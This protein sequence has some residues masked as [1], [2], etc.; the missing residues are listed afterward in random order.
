M[1]TWWKTRTYFA[2]LWHLIL[3]VQILRSETAIQSQNLKLTKICRWKISEPRREWYMDISE[4]T[5]QSTFYYYLNTEL[6]FLE[7]SFVAKWR[8]LNLKGRAHRRT[9]SCPGR[10]VGTRLES[11]HECGCFLPNSATRYKAGR[12][13]NIVGRLDST[14]NTPFRDVFEGFVLA[15]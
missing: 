14:E 12:W 2:L 13:D 11:P 4:V 15:D 3:V 9:R 10:I 5:K 7:F 8:C 1:L 6:V